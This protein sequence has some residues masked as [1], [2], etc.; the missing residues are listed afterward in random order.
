MKPKGHRESRFHGSMQGFLRLLLIQIT[1]FFASSCAGPAPPLNITV[2]ERNVPFVSVRWTAPNDSN[3]DSYRYHVEWYRN[4]R[5]MHSTTVYNTEVTITHIVPRR[6]YTL[7]V[8]SYYNGKY[9]QPATIYFTT[10]PCG[11]KLR[12]EGWLSSPG[13]PQYIYSN[14]DCVWDIEA[15]LGHVVFLT[16]VDLN[17]DYNYSP[18]QCNSAWLAVGYNRT[19]Q[20]DITMCHRSDIGRTI[21]SPSNT[22][23]VFYQTSVYSRMRRF[24]VTL[25]SQ[26]RSFLSCHS[27]QCHIH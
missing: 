27:W 13:Y 26:G 18:S 7:T 2:V 9:S 23:R 12:A 10:G 21:E 16:V 22:L 11:G 8:T 17:D 4:T 20:R 5:Q 24:N 1:V 6:N 25:S 14:T 3:K 15:P 19:S